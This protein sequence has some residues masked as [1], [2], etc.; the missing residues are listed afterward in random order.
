MLEKL[1]NNPYILLI[2]FVLGVFGTAFAIYEH[3]Y[4]KERKEITYRRF[5]NSLIIK[6]K[7]KLE[8]LDI[9]YD[10]NP[11]D[12]FA[13]SRILLWNSGNRTIMFDDMVPTKELS[14]EMKEGKSILDYE[15]LFSS[16]KTNNFSIEKINNNRINVNFDYID[17]N[18]GVVVQILH[19]GTQEDIKISCKIKGGMS[20]RKYGGKF[21][22]FG[23]KN[24]SEMTNSQKIITKI[25]MLAL[26]C[27]FPLLVIGSIVISIIFKILNSDYAFLY[28]FISHSP[29][30]Y[31][32]EIV[33]AL[34]GSILAIKIT[35][36][37]LF[38]QMP[39][40]LRPYSSEN[41]YE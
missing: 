26:F 16:E 21:V 13:V 5:T 18:D 40:L 35:H 23:I 29:K 1:M 15:I 41:M 37:L 11:I 24:E 34:F 14:I 17:K 19:T 10:G 7:S 28:N 27:F 8:K 33:P 4:N 32:M 22:L 12:D 39:K 25:I 36:D 31:F 38:L 30:D 9:K 2:S 3:Y 20:I 6:K